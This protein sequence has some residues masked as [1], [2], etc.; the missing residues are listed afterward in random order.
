MSGKK[1]VV[2]VSDE[3]GKARRVYKQKELTTEY[4]YAGNFPI[5]TGNLCKFD[6]CGDP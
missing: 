4:K 1:K 2:H 5:S 3:L 6:C